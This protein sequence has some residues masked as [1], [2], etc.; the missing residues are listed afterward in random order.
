[1]NHPTR[2]HRRTTRQSRRW[3]RGSRPSQSKRTARAAAAGEGAGECFCDPCRAPSGP[4]GSS[5]RRW[6][7]C[8]QRSLVQTSAAFSMPCR[9]RT[10]NCQC[11][12]GRG[13][14]EGA[15]PKDV[16]GM[17]PA[18]RT[19]EQEKASHTPGCR[20]WGAGGRGRGAFPAYSSAGPVLGLVSWNSGVRFCCPVAASRIVDLMS[21]LPGTGRH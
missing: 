18:D 12:G 21:A 16:D 11:S 8:T 19:G 5:R 9:Y 13:T 3:Y 17:Y 2:M 10:G 20:V 14:E 7:S 4:K 15:R 1:M 6:R